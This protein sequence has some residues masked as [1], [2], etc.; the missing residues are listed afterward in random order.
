MEIFVCFC[1]FKANVPGALREAA[2][3]LYQGV[4]YVR[5]VAKF[6]G[7]PVNAIPFIS[8]RKGTASTELT[9]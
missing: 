8:V 3:R 5:H 9:L 2:H 7:S 6:C 1:V 4:L